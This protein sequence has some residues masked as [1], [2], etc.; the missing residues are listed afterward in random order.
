MATNNQWGFYIFMSLKLLQG[1]FKIQKSPSD[2]TVDMSLCLLSPDF[3][4]LSE[5]LKLSDLQ[6]LLW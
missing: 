3:P 5:K 6:G 2:S 4:L 1:T